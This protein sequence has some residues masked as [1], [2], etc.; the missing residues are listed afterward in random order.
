[1]GSDHCPVY[2]LMKDVV[3]TVASAHRTS[4]TTDSQNEAHILDMMNPPGM[5]IEGIRQRDYSPIKDVPLLSGKLLT[6]FTKRRNI[7]DMFNKTAVLMKKTPAPTSIEAPLTSIV[8]AAVLTPKATNIVDKKYMPLDEA[9]L[10]NAPGNRRIPPTPNLLNSPEKRSAPSTSPAKPVKRSKSGGVSSFGNSTS[11]DKSQRSLKGFF[12]TQ[13]KSTDPS[14][15]LAVVSS[16]FA[17]K[18]GSDRPPTQPTIQSTSPSSF[19]G[20]DPLASQEA[21]K[22]GWTRLFSQKPPPRCEGHAEPCIIL[23]TKKPGVNC[24][25]QFWM[26]SRPIGPSGQKENGT[27]WRCPTFIWASDWKG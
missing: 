22:E 13:T 19:A 18:D 11:L 3:P 12:Q 1:M 14:P 6:E 7:R 27:Q 21:S 20:T 15:T 17:S 23:T 10:T 25:R 5:F 8:N 24:G 4:T 2:A 9:F 26:C 16:S